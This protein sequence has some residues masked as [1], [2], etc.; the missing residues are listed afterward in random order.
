MRFFSLSL[1]VFAALG[2][3]A[4][5]TFSKIKNIGQAPELTPME[6][7]AVQPR[8]RS[9]SVPMPHDAGPT[10]E[11]NSLW[12]TGARAFF[13]DQRAS[14]VGDIVTIRIEIADEAQID[15][16]T[17]RSRTTSE[18]SDVTNFLGLE[19]KL[20]DILP[21]EFQPSRLTSFGSTS[22]NQG[23]GSVDRKEEIQL[24][25]AAIVTDVLPNGNFV[26]H[27]RQEVRVNFEVREL[28][29]AGIVRPE[30]IASDNTIKHTQ[31][32]EARVSYGGRGH[33]TDVQQTRYGQQFYDI[34][35]PF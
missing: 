27:G 30:D 9:I 6:Q 31:I 29:V 28:Q 22:S 15:N 20:A 21:S 19:G 3:G 7:V 17:T 14:Q 10:S 13:K 26:V 18:D 11:P 32:A 5:G 8:Q 4:C 35:F 25:V 34:I 1:I 23:S 12:R 2:L 33:L 24:T 16:T